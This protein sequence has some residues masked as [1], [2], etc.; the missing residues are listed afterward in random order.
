MRI[1][2]KMILLFL[3]LSR[4]Y[5]SSLNLNISFTIWSKRSV[6]RKKTEEGK[7][8]EEPRFRENPCQFNFSIT[9]LIIN[10]R[11]VSIF[12]RKIIKVD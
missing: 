6:K 12:R 11:R 3:N 9:F 7:R 10:T 2:R 5:K 1:Y 8:K 4:K